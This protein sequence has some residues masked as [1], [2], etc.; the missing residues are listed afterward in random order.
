[1]IFVIT[2]GGIFLFSFLSNLVKQLPQSGNSVSPTFAPPSSQNGTNSND[3][4]QETI[5]QTGETTRMMLQPQQFTQPNFPRLQLQ[6]P[7][8]SQ[9]QCVTG[10]DSLGRIVTQCNQN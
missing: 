5:R 9:T 7:S 8:Q 2:F 4:L 10:Q 3:V 6:Q 1:M